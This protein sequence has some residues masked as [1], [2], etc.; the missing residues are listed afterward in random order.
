MTVRWNW[1]KRTLR[2]IKKIDAIIQIFPI[3]NS[4]A[5][6]SIKYWYKR[7]VIFNYN[8]VLPVFSFASVVF[9]SH[10]LKLCYYAHT[11]RILM[12]PWLIDLSSFWNI[13][14]YL[15]W[16]FFILKSAVLD[17]NIN[18]LA[19]LAF[20]SLYVESFCICY[21]KVTIV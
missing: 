17:I 15:R 12:S 9:F 11:F 2:Q 19:F 4:S 10:V 8:S 7:I 3:I 14:N 16:Y 21:I 6:F 1:Q 20:G 13:P 18:T 5:Y